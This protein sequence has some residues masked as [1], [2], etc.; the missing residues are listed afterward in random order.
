MSDFELVTGYIPGVIGRVA[1][2]HAQ[3]YS[4]NWG[5]H[6]YFEAKVATELSS[7]IESYNSEQDCIY[8]IVK[9]GK[10][11]GSVTIDGTSE[12]SNVAHLRWF[13]VSDNLRGLGA[14]NQLMHQAM[15]FCKQQAYDSV[16]LWT[17]KGLSSARH[18]YEKFG[19]SLT[20]ESTGDQWGATVTEQRFDAKLTRPGIG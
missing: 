11:E 4:S 10:I 7:F 13:I 1:E 12:A 8:S 2:L 3:Y 14:G 16:Y 19:F 17:F 6:S 20:E 18:L 9:G 15:T 5:F